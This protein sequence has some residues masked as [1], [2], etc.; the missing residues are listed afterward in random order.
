L[1]IRSRAATTTNTNIFIDGSKSGPTFQGV[2]A[3]SGGGGN[4]RLLIDY[5]EPQRSQILDYLF[6]YNYGAVIQLLKLE[7][8]ADVNS[9]DGAEPSIEHVKGEINCN[10]GY[11]W[12]LAAQAKARNPNIKLYGLQWG[13]PGWVSTDGTIWTNADVQYVID[14]LNCAKSH[15]LTVDYV[16]GWN[17]HGYNITWYRNLRAALNHNGFRSV[18]IVAADQ[19]SSSNNREWSVARAMAT[20]PAFASAVDVIGGHNACK[21]PTTGYTCTITSTAESFGKPLWI[22]EIG[23]MD[24]NKDAD[25]MVRSVNNAFIQGGITGLLEW[26]LINSMAPGLPYQNRGLLYAKQPWSG[27]YRVNKMTWA[28]AHTTQFVGQGWRHVGGGAGPI[29]DSGTYVAY[30]TRSHSK[31]SLVAENTGSFSGQNVS[32]QQITVT[33]KGGLAS[34]TVHVWQTNLWDSGTQTTFARQPDISPTNGAFTYTI[35]AGF[36]VTFTT[37]AGQAKG[38]TAGPPAEPMPLPYSATRDES[39]QPWGLG[40]QDGAF[41]YAPC[42]GGRSGSCIQQMAQRT[43][44]WWRKSKHEARF[45]YA[46]VGDASWTNYTVTSNI[47]FTKSS[48]SAGLIGRF[49]NQGA[50]GDKERFNGYQ[51]TLNAAGAWAIIKNTHASGPTTLRSGHT[52][53]PG[54]GHWRTISLTLSGSTLTAKRDGATLATVTDSSFASGIAGIRSNWSK[55][56]YNNL[57][58]R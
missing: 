26:P 15:E 9:S 25:A 42:L 36:V 46:V 7:I 33:V 39:G 49:S 5:P 30:Q 45:P 52:S 47:L 58:V 32:P 16:G 18:K 20:H 29:G 56:Q 43:P 28:I 11:E 21:Y 14:W 41:E 54:T 50:R 38:T 2:G 51:F 10:V 31:W 3:I 17:E 55:V 1:A 48:G 44:I 13:A 53:A 22:S 27:H 6:E 37:N 24:A 35:P 23:A 4:S 40:A 19:S 8:G 57:Q 34:S 12:W